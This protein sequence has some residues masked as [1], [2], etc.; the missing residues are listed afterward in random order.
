MKEKRGHFLLEI[1][2]YA[3]HENAT[4]ILD[5]RAIFWGWAPRPGLRR[6]APLPTSV[7]T[8][9]EATEETSPH[10]KIISREERTV[11]CA[12]KSGVPPL[13]NIEMEIFLK[14]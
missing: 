10:S 5:N 4:W 11:Q 2:S 9:E 3:C 13:G 14:R 8:L 1:E 12:V 7:Q 6:A